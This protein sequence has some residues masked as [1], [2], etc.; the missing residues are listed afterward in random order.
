MQPVDTERD[1]QPWYRQPWPWF[2][3]SIPLGTVIAGIATLIIAIQSP[4][5]LVVDDY[6]KAGLAINQ[7]KERLKTAQDL[8]LD[9]F[10]RGD[11]REISFSFTGPGKVRPK[12]LTLHVVHAT[13]AELDKTYTLERVDDDRY[14][15]LWEPLP[16]GGW[17][18]RLA[19][20]DNNWELRAQGRTE[21]PFQLRMTGEE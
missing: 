1:T 15:A 19:A 18:F 8:E 9:G 6:Y 5:A 13:R 21:G 12:T 17:Y 7:E 20:D 2:L 10:L 16:A 11:D 3:I 14:R 4:N